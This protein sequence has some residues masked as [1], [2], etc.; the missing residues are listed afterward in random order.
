MCVCVCVC[1]CLYVCVSQLDLYCFVSE[2]EVTSALP[3][4][5]KTET[6]ARHVYIILAALTV[7]KQTKL[8]VFTDT[9]SVS[10]YVSVCPSQ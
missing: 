10:V 7:D 8:S 9:M 5:Q 6:G 3:Y 4:H 2:E 1:V